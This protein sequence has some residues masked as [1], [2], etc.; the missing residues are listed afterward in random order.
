[1]RSITAAREEIALDGPKFDALTRKVMADVQGRRT[2]LK[3]AVAAAAAG[4]LGYGATE[5][6]AARP[7]CP[8]N[9]GCDARCRDTD[10]RC[11]CIRRANGDRTC[12]HPCCSD[13]RCDRDGECRSGEVCMR[14][15]CCTRSGSWCVPK[16]TANRPG[17]CDGQASVSAAGEDTGNAW[18]AVTPG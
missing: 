8:N 18:R 13:R 17:Y 16:C 7:R 2:A 9:T 5:E 4:L 12:I 3:T 14:T 6:A 15:E 10:R 11:F 1:M